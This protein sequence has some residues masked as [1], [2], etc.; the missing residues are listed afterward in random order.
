MSM[1]HLYARAPYLG[2]PRR[3]QRGQA[4]IE[5]AM[6]F[7]FTMLLL[8]G[9]VDIGSLLD[10]HVDIVYAARQGARTGAVVGTAATADCAII[11]AV[12]STLLNQPNLTVTQ[13]VI[14]RSTGTT[15]GQYT[16][17]QLA[18]IYPGSANCVNGAITHA[19]TIVELSV[20]SFIATPVATLPFPTIPRATPTIASTPTTN[21]WPPPNRNV[22]PFQEDSIGVEIDYTYQFQFNLLGT[23]FSANDFADYAMSPQGINTPVPTPTP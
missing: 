21:N 22:T 7:V 6:S 9:V 2:R 10:T 3:R 19:P 14:Y 12:Q 23:S 16:G 8:A 11:G 1:R 20:S 13:I 5:F 17:T 4:I 15:N 18:D